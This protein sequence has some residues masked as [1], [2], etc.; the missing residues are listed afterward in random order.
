MMPRSVQAPKAKDQAAEA[1]DLD[2]QTLCAESHVPF[3]RSVRKLDEVCR[4]VHHFQQQVA[5]QQ[6]V[7]ETRLARRAAALRREA[8]ARA[9]AAAS[10]AAAEKLLASSIQ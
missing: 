9:A 7:I 1:E 4:D 5:A 3:T 2:V 6:Q 8:A 10:R